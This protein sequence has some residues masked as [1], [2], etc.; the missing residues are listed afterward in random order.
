MSRLGNLDLTVENFRLAI[1]FGSFLL[2]AFIEY[3]K[4]FKSFKATRKQRWPSN[5]L[6]T[7]L[8]TL[9]LRLIMPITAVGFC[10][11][12]GNQ[13]WGLFNLLGMNW[14]VTLIGSVLLLDMIIYF[15]HRIFHRVPLLWRL[16]K[17][18]HADIGFDITT[19]ARFH[20][21]EIF[22]SM[23]IKFLSILLIGVSPEAILVFEILLSTSSNFNHG[24]FKFPDKVD[25]FIRFFIVTP[26]MHRI[27]H[28][29]VVSETDLNFSFSLSVWDRLFGTYKDQAG[30]SQI[31]I[32]I[33]LEEYQSGNKAYS[34]FELLKMPFSK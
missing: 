22:L 21:I 5:I 32:E 26:D 14:L 15:Q 11:Y 6:L 17:V 7:V 18:H 12:V 9:L 20:P 16:H 25:R 13:G 1:F 3:I 24:N 28:S 4:P 2:I 23:A 10:V 30:K 19:G 34:L 33:G 8:N 29:T 31:D 27:H